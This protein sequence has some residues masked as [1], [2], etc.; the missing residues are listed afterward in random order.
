MDSEGVTRAGRD[1]A[2][3]PRAESVLQRGVWEGLDCA[4]DHMK[5]MATTPVFWPGES[6]GQRSLTG[7]APGVTESDL[8]EQLTFS[9]SL[10]PSVLSGI[11]PFSL[12]GR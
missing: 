1:V 5:G 11:A 9:L 12:Q 6:H 10:W 4:A 7:T 8:T 2:G 3:L